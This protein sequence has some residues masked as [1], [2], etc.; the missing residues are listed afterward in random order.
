M[1]PKFTLNLLLASN[2]KLLESYLNFNNLVVESIDKPLFSL[3]PLDST[4]DNR[5][6]TLTLKHYAFKL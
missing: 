3:T 2:A 1:Y 6:L 5:L 4:G